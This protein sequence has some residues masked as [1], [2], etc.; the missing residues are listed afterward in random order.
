MAKK[1]VPLIPPHHTYVE[2]FGGSAA[3]L[4]AKPP[5]PVEVY[6]DLDS[7]VVN[8][9]RVIRDE[10]KFER[11]IFLASL[12][13]NSREEFNHFKDTWE[14]VEDDVE[15][16]YRWFVV[17]RQSFGGYFGKAWAVEVTTSTYGMVSSCAAYLSA[18][19]RLPEIH[20]RLRRVAI[21]HY[22][23]RKIF[24]I[25]DR[26]ETF[27]YIDPPYVG[28]TRKSGK[29]N[30]EMTLD[31]HRDLVNILLNL[32]GMAF[33]SG[34]YHDVYLPL[35]EAG[36]ERLEFNIPCNVAART[37]A[38]GLMGE[39]KIKKNAMRT[40]CLWISPSAQAAMQKDLITADNQG[41][42]NK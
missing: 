23:F 3:V 5:S 10:K 7:G 8:F 26:P 25:Y 13:P 39:G 21:E 32:Q 42:A 15:R 27:F 30:H 14:N 9:Y 31:D 20:K 24:D 41:E 4:M 28:E 16:A 34:Y 18:L 40:E 6:N 35:E 2:P 1:I 19:E 29:Y 11:L 12:T 37:R 33:L 22:D 38:H 36:W 17:A